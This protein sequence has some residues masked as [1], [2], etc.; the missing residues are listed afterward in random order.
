MRS[1][2]RS[3][4]TAGFA[5]GSLAVLLNGG[6]AVAGANGRRVFVAY[7]D[8]SP[9]APYYYSRWNPY[10]V[11]SVYDHLSGGRQLCYLATEPCDNNHR[12]QN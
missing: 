8:P 10:S 1:A 3:M 5:I 9:Y 12:V 2:I 7:P 11:Y 6:E 4:L